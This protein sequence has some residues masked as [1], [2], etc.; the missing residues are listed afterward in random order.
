[1]LPGLTALSANDILVGARFLGALPGY[2]RRPVDLAEARAI[3][4]RRLMRREVDFLTFLE[5]A[6]FGNPTSPYLTLLWLAGC[7]YGDVERLVA[8]DG[9]EG[10]LAELYRRGVY[11]TVGEMKGRQP[12]RR[13]STEVELVAGALRN[14]LAACHLIG[15]SGGSRGN[16]ASVPIDLAFIRDHA[17]NWRLVLEARGCAAGPHAQWTVPGG[18]S[19]FNLLESGGYGAPKE[20]WFAQVDPA[21]PSLHPRYRWSA[22]LLRLGGALAGVR[23][24]PPEYV[25]LEQPLPVARWLAEQVRAGRRPHL[26][27]P[28]SG[29][30]RLCQAGQ[31]AGM[32]LR[33]V[34]FSVGG[35]PLTPARLA[36]VHQ[37]GAEALTTYGSSESGRIGYGCLARDASDDQHL[38]HDLVALI[39]PGPIGAQESLP[40]E[41]LLT[42]SLRPTAPL[43]LLNVSLGDQAELGQRSCGCPLER[44]GWPLHL[45]NVRSFEKLSAGGMTFLDQ[46]VVRV[47]EEILPRRFGGGP[48]HYQLLEEETEA[49]RPRLRLLV[50]PAV[51]P[52][53]P[54]EVSEAF[55]LAIGG[56]S[57]AERVLELQWRQAGLLEVE[58]RAPVVSAA[59]KVLHVFRVTSAVP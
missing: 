51:G 2:L 7:E 48:L 21:A 49:G 35:E 19:L 22:R 20:R 46:D 28:A 53:D 34:Q 16:R 1:M 54:T 29:A 58:R 40:A 38:Y 27:T 37:A 44:E 45:R 31:A 42:T 15:Q 32:D 11:L 17:T 9:V 39:Q 14:P 50:D 56:G 41:A 26:G 24:P 47:L 13:G 4:R 10:A 33:G 23:L 25:P 43:I 52:L 8:R 5:R 6:V 30:V 3:V 59:G 18:Q 12:V 55:L 57:G 36:V